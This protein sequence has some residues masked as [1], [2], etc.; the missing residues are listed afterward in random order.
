MK[1]AWYFLAF[2]PSR[3]MVKRVE[4]APQNGG[5]I[6]PSDTQLTASHLS[7]EE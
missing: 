5:A 1:V 2:G 3:D 6:V 4:G 7:L